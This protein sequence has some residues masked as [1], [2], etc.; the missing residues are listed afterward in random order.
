MSGS[1]LVAGLCQMC[2]KKSPILPLWSI[3][4]TFD[5]YGRAGM[6][7]IEFDALEPTIPK[8]LIRIAVKA[9][10]ATQKSL[11]TCVLV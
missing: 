1:F 3:I 10:L 8:G 11:H 6:H 5:L 2:D 7:R 9:T 4:S